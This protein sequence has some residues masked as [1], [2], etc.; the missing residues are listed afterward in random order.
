MADRLVLVRIEHEFLLTSDCQEREHVAT[1]T[2]RSV[3]HEGMKL[4]LTR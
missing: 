1:H 4:P 2:T 3:H